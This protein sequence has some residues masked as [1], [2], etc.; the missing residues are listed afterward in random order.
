[1]VQLSPR[2]G[3]SS[4]VVFIAGVWGGNPAIWRSADNGQSF[5]RRSAPL[6]IDQWAAVD[7]TTLFVGSF[8]GSN[9]LVYH[10]SNSGLSYSAGVAAGSQSLSSFVLS[11]NYDQDGIILV[12][13]TNGWVY[14]SSD[15]GASFEPLPPTAA[16]PPL[17]GNV[18]V[19][20]DP[21]FASNNT[22]YAASDAPDKGIYRYIVGTSTGWQRIDSTLPAGGMIGQLAVSA[23]GVLYG[24]NFQQ[25][26][27]I[28]Q[29]GGLERCLSPGATFETV[30]RG[31]GDGV[32]LW[33]LW[34]HG[35][36]LWSIDT[37]GVRL[38]TYTDSLTQPPTLAS[39]LNQA[40]GIGVIINNTIAGISLD[41]EPLN[42]A[43][44][45]QWQIDD[46]NDF[47]SVPA[48]FEGTTAS[49]SVHL[50]VLQ[51]ATTYYWRVRASGPVLSPWSARWSFTT[52]LGGSVVT[53]SLVSPSA[54]AR[55]VPVRPLFQWSAIAGAEGYELV[56]SGDYNFAS[57]SIL[58]IGEY[59]LPGTAWQSDIALNYYTTYYWKVRAVSSSSSSA[60]SAIYIF[61][62]EPEPA[63]EPAPSSS[64]SPGV[65]SPSSPSLSP[66][67][68][69]PPPPLP[70]QSSATPDWAVYLM[71][72]MGLVI[73]LLLIT[74]VVMAVRRY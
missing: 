35:D 56:V 17:D 18:R 20:F 6:A 44:S 45:Y 49:S 41:W 21:Q 70:Q 72:L 63:P 58:R 28:N 66:P 37:T 32:T 34:L 1:M 42:G 64:P 24:V 29:E 39:P 54:G 36:Q 71:G 53:L 59:A 8:D 46:D 50:P 40:P 2:Y 65:E 10:T 73:M 67:S 55:D 16:S 23:D 69:P 52:S 9:G 47:T 57:P 4:W 68:S 26:D 48:G 22:V 7:D 51:P 43:T 61:I 38:M 15:N 19:A 13:N 27:I 3:S 12:G 60:W 30:T 31:L 11:P 33:G 62:T 25:V 74:I 5:S 14:W